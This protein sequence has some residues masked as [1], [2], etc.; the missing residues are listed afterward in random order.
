MIF[1]I[2]FE[3]PTNVKIKLI[4]KWTKSISDQPH[5]FPHVPKITRFH[6]HVF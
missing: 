4:K 6:L 5:L 3:T 2:I 1:V